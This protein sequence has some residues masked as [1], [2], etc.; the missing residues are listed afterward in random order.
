MFS[1]VSV[2]LLLLLI[3]IIIIVVVMVTSVSENQQLT[4]PAKLKKEW[5]VRLTGVG[6]VDV[7]LI[8]KLSSFFEDSWYVACTR[9][10][11]G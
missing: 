6:F 4:C 8:I 7:A 10:C 3:I 5:F 2:L 11:P 9:T 1:Y